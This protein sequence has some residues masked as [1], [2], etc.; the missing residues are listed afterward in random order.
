L[1]LNGLRISEALN[2]D[3]TDLGVDRG[4]RTLQIV[5]KGGKHVTIPLAPR[6]ATAL[7]LYIGARAGA[8]IFT[9]ATGQRRGHIRQEVGEPVWCNARRSGVTVR[10]DHDSD[11]RSRFAVRL[12]LSG[13]G[14]HCGFCGLV[15]LSTVRQPVYV[16]PDPRR[17][18][19]PLVDP[20]CR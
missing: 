12:S 17:G 5:R 19:W 13:A 1:A 20:A 18:R 6:T 11:R 16:R 4:H 14:E 15:V 7:D 9:G 2:A 8:P 3:V 10:H